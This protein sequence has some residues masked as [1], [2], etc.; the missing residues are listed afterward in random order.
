MRPSE[1]PKQDAAKSQRCATRKQ[2]KTK[3]LVYGVHHEVGADIFGVLDTKG[4]MYRILN[5]VGTTF[6]QGFIVR[7]TY[8]QN[9]FVN[10]LL[11]SVREFDK[12]VGS[13]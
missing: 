8:K 6:G 7:E 10:V 3:P 13:K 12:L 5:I 2:T 11:E 9:A 4:N 1:T